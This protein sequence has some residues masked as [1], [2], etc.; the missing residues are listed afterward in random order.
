MQ[1]WIWTLSILAVAG[2]TTVFAQPQG[3]PRT[4]QGGDRPGGDRGGPPGGGPPGGGRGPNPLVEAL[5]VDH[6]RVLSADELKNASDAL[7][8]LD[9]NKDGKLTEE[10]YR[11]AGGRGG[12]VGGPGGGREGGAPPNNRRG[13]TD[14]RRPE[15]QGG[16]GRGPGPGGPGGRGPGGPEGQ[17]GPPPPN[18]DRFIEHALEIDADKD[19]KL[20]K[21]E[22]RKF[23]EDMAS[24][25]GGPGGPGGGPG[26]QGRPRGEGDR[27]PSEDERPERPKRPE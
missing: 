27:P 16:P 8:A 15:G 23:A 17:V 3:G 21:D 20:S 24:R 18:A 22:L 14:G 11:P 7:L 5:D 2:V 6:D 1:R 26:D 13:G 4:G 19:G 25:R 9:R 12:I 10:E